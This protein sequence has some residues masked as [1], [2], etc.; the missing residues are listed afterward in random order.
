MPWSLAIKTILLHCFVWTKSYLWATFYSRTVRDKQIT[1]RYGMRI[2]LM[3]V[4]SFFNIS[5]DEITNRLVT[6][7]GLKLTKAQ[8]NFPWYN[9]FPYIFA[10]FPLQG[11]HNM[12][13][14]NV[15]LFLF[16]ELDAARCQFLKIRH[17]CSF[18]SDRSRN[19][20][21]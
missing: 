7:T 6:W 18:L 4:T 5:F 20:G 1:T 11:K 16:Q 15:F 8:T 21:P 2:E 17:R 3:S 10:L 19:Q 13:F 12:L 9:L 14:F